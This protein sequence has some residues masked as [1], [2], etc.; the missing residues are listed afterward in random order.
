M[1]RLVQ[2]TTYPL[3][4][5]RHGGQ[6]RSAAIR[7]CYRKIGIDV[8]TI[9]VMHEN[10][11]RASDRE[12]NDIALPAD[13]AYWD[14]K[15]PRFS[16]LQTGRFLIGD[17]LFR[18]RFFALLRRLQ[19]DVIQLE[20]PW[21]YPAVDRWFNE[22]GFNERTRPRLIYSAHNIEWMLKRDELTRGNSVGEASA[23]QIIEVEALER[24]AVLHS[25]LIIACTEKEL[26][27]LRALGTGGPATATWVTAHNGIAPFVTEATRADAM[28]RKLGLDRYSLFVG[29]A[30]PPNANGFWEMMAPSLAFLRPDEKIVVAGGVSHFLRDHEV[31]RTWIGINEPRLQLLGEVDKDDLVALLGGAAVILLP[32]TTGG[33]SNLK[34]AEAIYAGRPVLATAHALRGYGEATRWPTIT[35]ANT[36]EAFRSA[37]REMLDTATPTLSPDYARTRSEV[38]WERA[39]MPLAIAVR[40]LLQVGSGS[41]SIESAR[42]N[43]DAR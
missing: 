27:E 28:K 24:E 11:Y 13:S 21:L 18:E 32:I 19:P 6:L 1:T 42:T 3:K 36:P 39:L 30:H 35:I 20:Q 43:A 34:T 4:A 17:A 22:Q 9:A 10:F 7:E 8:E 25:Q 29:S 12:R 15:F 41:A 40:G 16:D 2:L 14:P 31:Y 38:T 26:I 33:G 23:A 37:L 5:P